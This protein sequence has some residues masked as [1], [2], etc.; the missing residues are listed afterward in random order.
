MIVIIV[1]SSKEVDRVKALKR[2]ISVYLALT[3]VWVAVHFLEH[4][5]LEDV[6]EEAS[7]GGERSALDVFMAV[8]LLLTVITAY[9]AVRREAGQSPPPWSWFVSNIFFYF[10]IL[11]AIPFFANWFASM[12]HTDDG[13]LWIYVE[14][15]GPL[16]WA[17]QAVRL[18]RQPAP[19]KRPALT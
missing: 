5:F 17:I 3:A 8:A 1:I 7:D 11:V 9:Q 18:W 13:L 2:T 10:T 15:A 4:T 16:T 14:T 12:G 6:V 19:A